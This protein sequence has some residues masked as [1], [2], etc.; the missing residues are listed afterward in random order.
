MRR[1]LWRVLG[2]QRLARIVGIHADQA[3]EHGRGAS[4]DLP[5]LLQRDDGVVERGRLGV[6]GDRLDF[7]EMLGHAAVEAGR[8]N[9]ILILS[10]CG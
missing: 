7:L 3:K 10:N 9:A 1:Q 8:E 4:E 6:A 2:L 5:G